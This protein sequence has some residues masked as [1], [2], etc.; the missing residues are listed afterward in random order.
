VEKCAL[1]QEDKRG[2]TLDKYE[3]KVRSQEI[4]DLIAQG[5]YV[6][7]AEIADTIDWRRV[8]SVMMLCTISDL[9]KINRRFE[10]SKE[11]LLL[12]YERHPG[13]RTI[14]YSLCEL[15]IKMGEF[16]QA[17]EYYK[18]FVQL[19]PKDTGRYVLQYKLYVAQEVSLEERIE[20][21]EELK[22]RDYREKWAYELAYLYHRV[23][24]ATR[25][26]EECDELI[27]W[28]GE[29]K[30]VTKAMEL[31]MLHQP[32]TSEQQAKYE[33]RFD[34]YRMEQE[35]AQSATTLPVDE[36][37]PIDIMNAPTVEISS[38]EIE[39][40]QVKTMDVGE[41]NT[42]NLQKELADS[43]KDLWEGA[44]AEQT[45]EAQVSVET[46][47]Y[48]T[49]A[50]GEIGYP[51][52]PEVVQ[53]QVYLSDDNDVTN[54]ENDNYVNELSA[55][56]QITQAIV[57]PLFEQTEDMTEMAVQFE[58]EPVEEEKG[59]PE[60]ESVQETQI[61]EISVE[62]V[63]R[64]ELPIEEVLMQAQNLSD[65]AAQQ[66]MADMKKETTGVE[67][68]TS[69]VEPLT[70]VI[71][72]PVIPVPTVTSQSLKR[73][74]VFDKY[75]GMEY[76][77]QMSF[78]VP[79]AEK[80]EKQITG[81]LNIEDILAEWERMKKEN[82]QK[83]AEEVRQLVLQHTGNILIDF[84]QAAKDGLLEKL[85]KSEGLSEQRTILEKSLSAEETEKIEEVDE[86]E[87]VEEVEETESIEK[88]YNL[89][90]T[91]E[92]AVE[93]IQ[94]PDND[95]GETEELEEIEEPAESTEAVIENVAQNV[96][97]I[98]ETIE[99][100]TEERTEEIA[101]AATEE[102]TV[103]ERE[104]AQEEPAINDAVEASVEVQTESETEPETEVPVKEES[105]KVS[106]RELTDEEKE[107]YASFIQGRKSKEQL[108]RAIDSISLAPYTGNII[109]TGEEGMDTL[110]LAKNLMKEV[111]MTDSNFSG[112]IAKISGASMNQRD[113]DKVISKLNNGALIIENA[114]KM[115]EETAGRLYKSLQ[116]ENMGIVVIMEGPKKSINKLLD[117]AP[118]LRN[119]F[120]AC[121]NIEALDN[122]SLVAF[123]KKYAKEQEYSID[124]MG[125]LALH[126]RISDRQT[127][128]HAV[129]LLEV[130]EMVDDAIDHANKKSLGHFFDILFAKRYDEEDMIILRENDFI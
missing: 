95:Y 79:E 125:L 10:E 61:Q 47:E 64:E 118:L 80:V 13:G 24:L 32:L 51:Q 66:V 122:D 23:G 50:T 110:T 75:L 54:E 27:L 4:R 43:M 1:M 90:A 78:V 6:A 71:S 16:V 72:T 100:A 126:T 123:G 12:A 119:C 60:E 87:E 31:K 83:Q 8:K 102:T 120:S 113:L 111:Q 56:Q 94:E 67:E 70:P 65:R 82:E 108:V 127:S 99:E 57:A 41:Y 124:E 91:D 59:M 37:N 92:V 45:E 86:I 88:V 68:E 106:L 30:Y 96:E 9:Y 69:P 93:V 109:I 55:T 128:N 22:K 115:N 20:V 40:I 15:S 121:V 11:L 49:S 74:E 76:D 73:P 114:G 112:K 105:D 97:E 84:D 38:G 18:E 58:P 107:L 89:S 44:S 7:A 48:F 117:A 33:G 81:Q 3:Y 53:E 52:E 17:I 35:A 103:T 14:I 39:D 28:F 130:K 5:E 101:E 25:C 36:D 77:G 21:L 116:Q 2:G 29:G 98:K 62:Q 85:E 26:V 63:L 19:A 104:E 46:E 129:T 42:I 34:E